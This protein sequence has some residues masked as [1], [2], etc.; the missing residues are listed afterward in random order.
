MK[1]TLALGL[2]LLLCLTSCAA[3]LE[4][5]YLVTAQHAEDAPGLT[6]DFYRVE[7]YPGLM[8]SLNSYIE[9]GRGS[10]T[11]H[12]PTTYAGNLA[13]DLEKAKRQL[14]EDEPYGV[15]AISDLSYH[16]SR[17]ISYYEVTLTFD[18]RPDILPYADL[19]RVTSVSQLDDLLTDALTTLSQGFTILLSQP[20][21]C[22]DALRESLDRVCAREPLLNVGD[23]KLTVRCFP[24]EGP[25][26]VAQ[27]ELRYSDGVYGLTS[28]R[29][30]ARNAAERTVAQV[31][32]DPAALLAALHEHYLYTPAEGETPPAYTLLGDGTDRLWMA[33]TYQLLCR[34][35]GLPCELVPEGELVLVSVTPAPGEPPLLVDPN[36]PMAL[37]PLPL[38]GDAGAPPSEGEEE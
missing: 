32:A 29:T 5:D 1:R 24:Q 19:Q 28:L 12:F 31:G 10:G 30:R 37:A 9:E 6:E 23:P 18:Y 17:I 7:T 20:Q 25:R 13:V 33:R 21:D 14:L 38:E 4:R 36:D 11:L 22:Q 34:T 35:A 15:Y 2:S 27:V 26:A 3:I 8:A 16:I